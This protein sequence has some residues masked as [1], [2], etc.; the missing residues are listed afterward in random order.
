MAPAAAKPGKVAGRKPA[1]AP[2]RAEGKKADLREPLDYIEAASRTTLNVPDKALRQFLD[3]L[4][5]ARRVFLYGRGRSGFVA[6]AFAVRLMHLGYQTYV[7]GETITAPVARNDV[8]ILVSGTGTTYPVV[9]TAELGR[10]QGA[11]VVSI[12]AQPDS[13]I[14]RL[15]HIV[16]PLVP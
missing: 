16:I 5:P 6:R 1:A 7:V 11:T 13:E 10:R 4:Q 12:T 14:A 2:A 8:V 9:M 3:T 15:A